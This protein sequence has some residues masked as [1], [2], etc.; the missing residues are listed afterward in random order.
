[1]MI[2]WIEEKDS[3]GS[4]SPAGD[5]QPSANSCWST[6][7]GRSLGASL[8]GTVEPKLSKSAMSWGEL[9]QNS[10]LQ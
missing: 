1:M 5:C 3:A 9:S 10:V 7:R 4:H 2:P 6:L 8:A